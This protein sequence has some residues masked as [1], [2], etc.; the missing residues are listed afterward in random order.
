MLVGIILRNFKTYQTLSYI[1]LSHSANFTAFVGINGAGKSSILEALNS[2][3]NGADWNIHYQALSKGLTNREAVICPVFLL[4]KTD[5]QNLKYNWV[6]ENL[7]SLLWSST[8]SEFN[9]SVRAAATAFFEH[10]EKIISEGS[11]Q[12]THYLIPLGLEKPTLQATEKTLSIFELHNNF[13]ALKKYAT[14]REEM[15]KLFSSVVDRYTY[16]YIPAEIDYQEYTRIE[17]MTVQALLGQKLDEIVRDFVKQEVITEINSKLKEFLDQIASRLKNYEYKK[18]ARKQSL[19]NRTHL[20]AK[21][22]EAYF[23]SRVLHKGSGKDIIPVGN[24]SSGEKRQALI[25]Y[26]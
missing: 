23:D 15:S 9:T 26:L 6:A 16:I 4:K 12:E 19:V 25:G 24:L 3:F 7:S 21:I 5:F 22:I 17:G 1:P 13:P 18:P 8:P 11:S 2:Y 10:K 14:Y 20:T